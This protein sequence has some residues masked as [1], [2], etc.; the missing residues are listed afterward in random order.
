VAKLRSFNES[1][2]PPTTC[3]AGTSWQHH[4]EHEFCTGQS[5]ANGRL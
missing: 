1:G 2:R 3:S 4:L 5:Q